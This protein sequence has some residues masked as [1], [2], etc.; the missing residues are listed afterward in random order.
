MCLG[1]EGF[2]WHTYHFLILQ[3]QKILKK[4]YEQVKESN[5][6]S[7]HIEIP[8]ETGNGYRFDRNTNLTKNS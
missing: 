2:S 7:N 5:K 1:H 8:P 3:W 4:Q 6:L